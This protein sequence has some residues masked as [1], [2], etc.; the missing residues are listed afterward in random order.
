[1]TTGEDCLICDADGTPVGIGGIMGGASTEIGDATPGV[2]LEAAYFAP[3]A[4]ARTAKRLG[5]RT[6]ASARFERGCDPWGSTGPSA[7]CAA[8]LVGATA[9]HGRGAGTDRRAR[10]GARRRVGPRVRTVAG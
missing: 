8:I 4:V 10:R 3:M 1:M 2:L 7:R 6:E 9:G 5:L